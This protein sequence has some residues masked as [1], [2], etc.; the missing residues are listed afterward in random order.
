ML[1]TQNVI[2]E[3]AVKT[4]RTV[5]VLGKEQYKVTMNQSSKTAHP[6]ENKNLWHFLFSIA[7]LAVIQLQHVGGREEV[8]M[9]GLEIIPER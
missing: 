7:S 4:V 9:G 2:N 8:S 1:D 3:S 6:L 5:E